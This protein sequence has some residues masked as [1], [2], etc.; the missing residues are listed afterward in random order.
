MLLHSLHYSLNLKSPFTLLH[1]CAY[2]GS[3]VCRYAIEKA[4]YIHYEAKAVF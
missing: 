2:E 4:T 1:E 3:G